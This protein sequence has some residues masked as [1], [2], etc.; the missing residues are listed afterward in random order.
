MTLDKMPPSAN[1]HGLLQGNGTVIV[2]EGSGSASCWAP[3][4]SFAQQ[5][6]KPGKPIRQRNSD[7]IKKCPLHSAGRGD[8]CYWEAVLTHTRAHW[9]CLK[10]LRLPRWTWGD[11]G[12]A[13]D[14][15]SDA[16]KSYSDV[17]VQSCCEDLLGYKKAG[18]SLYS[19]TPKAKNG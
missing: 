8:S 10:K 16:L 2:S 13:E 7:G 12:K 19:Q 5:R 17:M 9:G 1:T 15:L 18:W 6:Q 11:G 14:R 4:T 3:Q